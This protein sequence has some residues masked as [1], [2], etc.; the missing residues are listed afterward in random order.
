MERKHLQVA[1]AIHRQVK[2]TAID[3]DL[4]DWITATLLLDYALAHLDQVRAWAESEEW[5]VRTGILGD[6]EDPDQ[7]A[8]RPA[9]RLLPGPSPKP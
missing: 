7:P 2:A 6:P 8:C 4:D 5:D 9:L 1:P 3:F